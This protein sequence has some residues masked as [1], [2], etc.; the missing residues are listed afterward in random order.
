MKLSRLAIISITVIAVVIAISSGYWLLRSDAYRQQK[1]G[2]DGK[3]SS[4]KNLDN[5]IAPKNNT[6]MPDFPLA[7]KTVPPFAVPSFDVVRISK[8]GNAVIAGR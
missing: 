3:L 5:S 4:E 7:P 8:E 1:F 2:A 6:K